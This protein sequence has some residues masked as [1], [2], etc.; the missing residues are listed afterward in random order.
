M[1]RSR[2]NQVIKDM[3]ALAK[4]NGYHLPPFCNWTPEE[5]SE[6]GHECDEIRDNK[7]G[8]DITD[9]GL[10]RFDEIGFALVTIR[11]GNLKDAKYKKPYAEK[12]LM[13][14]PGQNSPLH[15]HWSKMEDIINR[16]GN[17]LYITVF[18]GADGNTKLDTDVTVVT[19]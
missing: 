10:G 9:Y 6:K 16:G 15:Y 17:D 7:L 1:K 4:E 14:Y 3:E 12:L 5:W 13:L 8:W 18:N 2:I 19:D 11:N